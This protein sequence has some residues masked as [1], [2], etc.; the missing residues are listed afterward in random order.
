MRFGALCKEVERTDPALLEGKASEILPEL[1]KH[2]R[3]KR[4]GAI[5]LGT[6][7]VGAMLADKRVDET[8]FELLK[9]RFGKFFGDA[10]SYDE[11]V[12][13]TRNASEGVDLLVEGVKDVLAELD[14]DVREQVV[15]VCLMICAIDGKVS[16]AEKR[17]IKRLIG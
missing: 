10:A 13:I 7:V 12:E 2:V 5:M 11:C 8:E 9:P 4:S 3:N 14:E 16:S 1:E 17:W 6:F 15:L